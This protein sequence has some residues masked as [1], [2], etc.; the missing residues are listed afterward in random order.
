MFAE[1]KKWQSN[2]FLR[3]FQNVSKLKASRR[4]FVCTGRC[5][6]HSLLNLGCGVFTDCPLSCEDLWRE[7]CH[8]VTVGSV[9]LSENASVCQLL[10][11]LLYQIALLRCVREDCGTFDEV[12]FNHP[13]VSFL[14]LGKHTGAISP[15]SG[16]YLW[17]ELTRYK[18][19][20][21]CAPWYHACFPTVDVLIQV[22]QQT[23][24]SRAQSSGLDWHSM[25]RSCCQGCVKS[26]VWWLS[27]RIVS[28]RWARWRAFGA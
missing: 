21:R 6:R 19:K 25:V 17:R 28:R 7:H 23:G 9:L 14:K 22:F 8:F 15:P 4:N 16:A 20:T 26:G 13:I 27:F 18:S 3:G 10:V 12:P 1:T 11:E 5:F 2:L 24:S